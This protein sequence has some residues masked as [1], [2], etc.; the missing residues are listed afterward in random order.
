[1]ESPFTITVFDG[2]FRRCGW[3]GDP[4]SLTATVRHNALS[5]A[6]VTIPADHPRVGDVITPGARLVITYRGEHLLSGPVVKVTGTGPTVTS[7][8][9]LTV[10][11]DWRVLTRTLAWPNP[12]GP[13]TAQGAATA[14]DRKSGPAESVLKH[15]AG[16]NFTRL[17]RPVTVAPD[18]GRGGTIDVQAR[19]HPL[20][21]RLYPAVDQA[22]IGVSVRQVGSGLVLD[23]Y[24]PTVRRRVLSEDSGALT[25]W[26]WSTTAPGCTRVVVGGAG[27]GTAREFLHVVNADLEGEWRD[28]VEEFRDARDVGGDTTDS[29]GNTVP[30]P[31]AEA[32]AMLRARGL[33]RLTEA[34]PTSGLSLTLAEAAGFRYGQ[35]VRVGDT[36]TVRVGPGVTVTDILREAS[37]TYAD[38]GLEVTPVVGT[39]TDDPDVTLRRAVND[40][41]RAVRALRTR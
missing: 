1:M 37:L 41:A 22:G 12:T 31:P 14:Y 25:G 18:L 4:S 36:L 3:I 8:I 30:M 39:R 23:C 27:E 10:E 6:E 7:T 33:E 29:E 38:G 24:A 35:H 26:E 28:V 34:A 16:R 15:F 32:E 17:A 19:M 2:Q 13:I 11:D 21:D 9:T 5:V 20:S 40:L